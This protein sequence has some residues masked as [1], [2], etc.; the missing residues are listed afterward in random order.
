MNNKGRERLFE[1]LSEGK[2]IRYSLGVLQFNQIGVH[3]LVEILIC[4][5]FLWVVLISLSFF[6]YTK[7]MIILAIIL[8]AFAMPLWRAIR[9]KKIMNKIER[10]LDNL[11][12]KWTRE[13]KH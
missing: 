13:K 12:I 1:E 6:Q 9:S 2:K 8:Y 11:L 4:I 7:F 5:A 10:D 3:T